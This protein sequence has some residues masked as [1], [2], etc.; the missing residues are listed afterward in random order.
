MKGTAKVRD[1]GDL[2]TKRSGI[3]SSKQR[4]I[5][6]GEIL[7]PVGEKKKSCSDGKGKRSMLGY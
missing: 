6:K 3:R 7:G 4:R 2:E 5:E 1:F